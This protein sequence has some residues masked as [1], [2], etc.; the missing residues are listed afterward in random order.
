MDAAGNDIEARASIAWH[1]VTSANLSRAAWGDIQK[2]GAQCHIRHYELGVLLYPDLW[3]VKKNDKT[4]SFYIY[5][6]RCYIQIGTGNTH[7]G[8]ELWKSKAKT[9]RFRSG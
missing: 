3:E 4:F 7:V 2:N 1:L 8:C 6:T 9:S 5:L